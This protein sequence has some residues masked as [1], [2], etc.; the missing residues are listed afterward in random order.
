MGNTFDAE[1]IIAHKVCESGPTRLELTLGGRGGQECIVNLT[2]EVAA[3][4]ARLAG[5]FAHHAE[6]G[7]LSLTK[8]P[9]EFAIGTGVH[10]PVVLVRFEND[11][12]YGL[13]AET[14]LQL[15]QALI[16]E[17]GQMATQALP[18]RH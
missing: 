17:A 13:S 6:P 7:G 9:S 1:T 10:D 2:P 18:R 15:G 4:I 5:E 11:T 14:A 12:P 8:M 3:A 16:K